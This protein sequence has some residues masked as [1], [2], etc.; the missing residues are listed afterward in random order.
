[1][2][3][4]YVHLSVYTKQGIALKVSSDWLLKL[5]ISF[6]TNLYEQCA[7]IWARKYCNRCRKE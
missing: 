4:F 1:M 7:G 2:E 3:S 5:R 6:T